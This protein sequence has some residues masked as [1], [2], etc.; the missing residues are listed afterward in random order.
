MEAEK[1]TALV[2]RF[3]EEVWNSGNLDVTSEV[4]A[5]DYVRHDLRPSEALPGPAGQAKVAADFR[6]AFPDLRMEVDSSWRREIS[7]RR[8]GRRWGRTLDRGEAVPRRASG[9]GSPG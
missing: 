4:F 8:G 9:H 6:A 1:N 2:L 3:Y 7:W 5:P